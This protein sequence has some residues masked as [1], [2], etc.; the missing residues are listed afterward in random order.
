MDESSKG[1]FAYFHQCCVVSVTAMTLWTFFFVILV[2]LSKNVLSLVLWPLD[3][4]WEEA[5]KGSLVNTELGWWE[6]PRFLFSFSFSL[7]S[8]INTRTALVKNFSLSSSSGVYLENGDAF[9]FSLPFENFRNNPL[10]FP[11]HISTLYVVRKVV[12]GETVSEK[13]KWCK[14]PLQS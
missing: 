4:P 3:S 13:S 11:N 1:V 2:G 7:S 9:P 8:L 10:S 14:V 6:I 5:I 12:F